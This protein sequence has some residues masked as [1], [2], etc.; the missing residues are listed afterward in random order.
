MAG[1]VFIITVCIVTYFICVCEQYELNK[2]EY[3]SLLGQSLD[4]TDQVTH[5]FKAKV[6]NYTVQYL[7]KYYQEMCYS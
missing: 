5:Y 4:H 7:T 6:T 1:K 2:T 3:K